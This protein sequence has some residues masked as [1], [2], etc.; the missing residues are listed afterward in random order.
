M[1]SN[2]K[3]PVYRKKNI[4]ALQFPYW[5]VII[6]TKCKNNY[7][8]EKTAAGMRPIPENNGIERGKGNEQE[9]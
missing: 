6:L 8:R 9:I 4:S 1:K 7:R 2:E 3:A 5:S